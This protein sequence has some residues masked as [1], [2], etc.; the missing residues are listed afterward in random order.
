MRKILRSLPLLATIVAPLMGVGAETAS[1]KWTVVTGKTAG[2]VVEEA[3]YLA[4]LMGESLGRPVDVVAEERWNGDGHAVFVG[5]SAAAEAAGL[6]QS[7]LEAEEYAV[8]SVGGNVVVNGKAAIGGVYA[9]HEFLDKGLGIEHFDAFNRY[10]PTNAA[11]DL[12]H[13]DIRRRP[14]FKLR[15][16]FEMNTWKSGP[17]PYLKA[18]KASNCRVTNPIYGQSGNCH[19]FFDY[20]KDWPTNRT[21]W[22]AKD[23]NG[24]PRRLVGK[25]GPCFCMTNRDAWEDFRRK[26]LK[27]IAED[28]AKAAKFGERP[29]YIYHVSP[30]DGCGYL[31][32]CPACAAITE[33][34]GESA[35]LLDFINFLAR[36]VPKDRPDIRVATFA[37]GSFVAPPKD[38]T[39]AEPNVIID[40]THVM[41]SYYQPIEEDVDSPYRSY[42]ERWKTTGAELSIWDYWVFYWDRFPSAYHNVH[43]LGKDIRFYHAANAKYLRVENESCDTASFWSLKNWLGY[44]LMDDRDQDEK[45]LVAKFLRCFYGAAAPEM[46]EL[47]A[48][49]AERQ[50]GAKEGPFSYGN[51]KQYECPPRPWLDQSFFAKTEDIFRRAEAKLPEGSHALLNVRRERVPIDFTLMN[52]YDDIA[53]SLTRDELA[54]RYERCA[55]A[56]AEERAADLPGRRRQIR[57]EAD[58]CRKA[59]EIR[60]N[61]ASLKPRLTIPKAPARARCGEWYDNNGFKTDRRLELDA[62]VKD[63]NVLEIRLADHDVGPDK[64]KPGRQVWAG[65]RWEVFLMDRHN[66]HVQV[67]AD[68]D[69]RFQVYLGGQTLGAAKGIGSEGVTVESRVKGGTW[70]MKMTFELDKLPLKDFYRGD[71]FRG[72]DMCNYAWAPTYGKNFQQRHKF[73]W[74]DFK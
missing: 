11:P 6:T 50:K 67:I 26:L 55:T 37:Y 44:R 40:L 3:K 7:T 23:E 46:G 73:G 25:L 69:G 47:L 2:Q 48:Y 13:L 53:P 71:F 43:T 57:S 17:Y 51:Y 27:F 58:C 1:D 38:D 32:K 18:L 24:N 52:I 39:K 49:M 22:L 12:A 64:P 63:G 16:I 36:A 15:H 70:G 72:S 30:N 61:Q 4:A 56:F 68:A 59:D 10:L 9:I 28:E 60:A 34:R 21:D 42:V 66:D 8:K 45:K 5:D 19:T 41:G 74:I 33:R 54:A 65:E 29:P 62:T 14:D 31:C 20:Q 35:L